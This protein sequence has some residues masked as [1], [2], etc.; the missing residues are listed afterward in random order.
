MSI[1]ASATFD[2]YAESYDE[3]LDAG[4]SISGEDRNFF[5][6]GRI[7]WLS[8]MLPTARVK[9]VMDY[10]CGTG[11]ATP[12]LLDLL[13]AERVLGVDISE[14]SLAQARRTHREPRVSFAQIE[15]YEPREEFDLAFCNGVFHHIPVGERAASVAYIY[16]S[17]KPGGLFAFWE[18]NPWNPG[19]RYA[20]WRCP[21]D[22]DAV[23]LAPPAA[24]RLL[25]S[26]GFEIQTTSFLFIFPRVL[27]F[28]RGIEPHV[29]RW[30]LGAQYQVLCRKPLRSK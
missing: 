28:M 26:S 16:R 21:F 11:T 13:G 30:P 9:A 27:G 24:R 14:K 6:H 20:M 17:L 7:R 22:Q 19:A 8:S 29:A 1:S 4:I 5:A 10:G 3:A 2:Q 18:N 25:R 15:Q 12:F 23:A